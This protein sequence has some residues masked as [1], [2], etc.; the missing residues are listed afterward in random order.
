MAFLL[1][2]MAAAGEPASAMAARLP[3]YFRRS[4]KTGYEHGQLG[5]LMQ[6]LE[7]RFP[8]AEINRTDGLKLRMKGRWV[9]VRASN[10]EPVMRMTAEARSEESADELYGVVAGLLESSAG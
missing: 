5:S 2:R 3:R 4:G 8:E 1:D 6:A 10:T 7:E 9:H